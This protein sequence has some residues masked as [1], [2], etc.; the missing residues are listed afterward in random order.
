VRRILFL[1]SAAFPA[2]SRL[3]PARPRA[4]AAIRKVPSPQS[5]APKN[6]TPRAQQPSRRHTSHPH[7]GGGGQR[8]AVSR[9]KAQPWL[10]ICCCSQGF[11]V[12]RRIHGVNQHLHQRNCPPWSQSQPPPHPPALPQSKWR[13]DRQ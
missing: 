2:T 7:T 5:V 3:P 1:G 8:C 10:P 11:T 13:E 4:H 6:V 9:G 12:N